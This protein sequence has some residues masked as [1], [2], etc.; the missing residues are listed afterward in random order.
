MALT[1]ET[2]I[3]VADANS[4]VDTTYADSFHSIR[5]NAAW[6]GTVA[7]KEAAL[8]K[9]F[10]YL[11]NE[12][13]YRFRGSRTTAVQR[14]PFPR[15]GCQERNGPL[16]TTDQIPWRVKDA[17]CLLALVA[18]SGPLE[19]SLDRG[20]KITSE[21]VG[22]ISTSYAADAPVETVY[23]GVNG[24]LDPIL[25]NTGIDDLTELYLTAADTED[26]YTSG[27]YDN[28]GRVL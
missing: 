12:Q 14:A 22:P 7:A 19:S 10:D 26:E 8:A 23:T 15:T 6:T 25:T 28:T 3:G 24:I 27:F 20:G 16:Y 18:L 5:G 17:Q 11:C 9:A 4:Y 21:S 13:R 1:L 2:G